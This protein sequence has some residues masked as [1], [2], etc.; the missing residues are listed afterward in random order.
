MFK[1]MRDK[2]NEATQQATARGQQDFQ[3]HAAQFQQAAAAQ[4]HDIRPQLPTLGMATQ[5][6][7]GLNEDPAMVAFMA[8]PAE[9]QLRQQREANAYGQNLRRLH[10]TGEPATVVI[11]TLEATGTSV[12]GQQ[13]YR[14]VLEVSRA[15]G[16]TYRTTITH[17]V[18]TMTF[19]QY[20]PGTK[21]DARI[22]PGDPAQVG[23]FGLVD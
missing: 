23:V 12:A 21:H 18:P 22:D 11:R 6:M 3:Q 14:S 5:A 2:I 4:G 7:Q 1:K 9:E 17:L 16:T 19:P 15:N 13:Q 10:E 8:L 20:A